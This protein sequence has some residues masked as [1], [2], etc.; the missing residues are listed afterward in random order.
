MTYRLHMAPAQRWYLAPSNR[1]RL[2]REH[3]KVEHSYRIEPD[4]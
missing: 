3:G 4:V 1:A 2:S